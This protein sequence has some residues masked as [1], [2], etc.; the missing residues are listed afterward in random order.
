MQQ[1]LELGVVTDMRL[2]SWDEVSCWVKRR[3]YLQMTFLLEMEAGPYPTTLRVDS[4]TLLCLK[5]HIPVIPNPSFQ[6]GPL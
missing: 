4:K 5:V 3:N 2:H 1:F 6:L